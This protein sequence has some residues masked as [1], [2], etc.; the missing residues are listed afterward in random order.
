MMRQ[1]SSSL[2]LRKSHNPKNLTNHQCRENLPE[3]FDKKILV[4]I[5]LIVTGKLGAVLP[6]FQIVYL[7]QND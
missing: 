3:S 5:L 1:C 2:R 6:A 7:T 4:D